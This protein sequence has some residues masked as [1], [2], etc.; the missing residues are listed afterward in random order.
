MT[1]KTYRARWRQ[2]RDD[3]VIIKA[4]RYASWTIAA[5]M[6]R[7]PDHQGKQA[8]VLEQDYQ[9]GGPLLVNNLAAKLVALLFP[10]GRPFVKIEVDQELKDHAAKKGIT[11]KELDGRYAK[12]E[13]DACERLF[14]NASYNQLVQ[15][16]KH[17]IVTGNAL[18]YRDSAAQ[19][20]LTYGVQHFVVR[21]DG[22]GVT[23]EIIL[24]EVMEFQDLPLDVQKAL[25]KD[26]K[27][28]WSNP[29]AEVELYTRVRREPRAS[30]KR[31]VY[32]ESQQADIY[33]VGKPTT[34]PEK[35]CP[36][37]AVPWDLVI[38]EHYGRGLVENFAG[39]FAKMSDM[40][41]A[42][43]LYGIAAMKVVN[44]V[45]PG[46][47]GDIDTLQAA[48]T[49]EY[50]QG[51]PNSIKGLEIG[52]ANKIAQMLAMID[53]TFQQLAKA[54]MYTGNVR[55][56]ERVTMY[57]LQL[58]AKEA[59]NTLGGAFSSLAAYMQEPLGH[60]LIEEV[61][62]GTIVG[63]GM[64]NVKLKLQSGLPAL[65]R[66]AVVTRL[67]QASQEAAAILPVISG[68][69]GDPRVDRNRVYDLIYQGQSV[70]SESIH[71]SDKELEARDAADAQREE[72]INQMQNAAAGVNTADAMAA[73]NEVSA[74]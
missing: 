58:Q 4:T 55:D 22:K 2:L 20:V 39:G 9:E 68:E 47:S 70:D 63:V 5:L 53:N 71:L 14:A 59:E 13:L 19:R 61:D 8:E 10:F 3:H 73:L 57:E 64:G 21:R 42:L 48:E 31:F 7:G 56:A 45:A 30:G 15:A 16:L 11:A 54:F 26:S 32:V 44:L 38:G 41:E 66:S 74:S 1:A 65:G 60:V 18:L 24:R 28:K 12:L 72:G 35:Q 23:Q 27:S 17:L 69:F 43:A 49:G 50:A 25:L 62:P 37:V 36:W 67:A 52:E 46:S 6:A 33:P 29:E 34:Y 51:D 40:S